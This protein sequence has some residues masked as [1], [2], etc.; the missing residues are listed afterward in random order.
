MQATG[1]DFVSGRAVGG[2]LGVSRPSVALRDEHLDYALLSLA[3]L[4]IRVPMGGGTHVGKVRCALTSED[5][6]TSGESE[7]SLHRKKHPRR[8]EGE[9]GGRWER[10]SPDPLATDGENFRGRAPKFRS[11][12]GALVSWERESPDLVAADV[13]GDRAFERKFGCK[14]RG[15]ISSQCEQ[16][17]AGRGSAGRR[18]R[19]VT[20]TWTTR[21]CPW[22]IW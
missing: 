6:H 16:S 12:F 21:S 17:E 10:G 13:D 14:P 15:R 7:V 18:W 3:D 1:A 4:V 2:G 20:S 9:D 11:R 5:T 19:S 8:G 22:R